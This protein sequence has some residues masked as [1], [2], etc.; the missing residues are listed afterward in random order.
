MFRADDIVRHGEE[1]KN[2]NCRLQVNI[3]SFAGYYGRRHNG[4]RKGCTMQ[5]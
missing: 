1:L 2:K 5:G 4:V 3:L